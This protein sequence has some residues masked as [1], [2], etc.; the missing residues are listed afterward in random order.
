MKLHFEKYEGTGNDFV[1][2]DAEHVPTGLDWHRLAPRL[3]DRHRGVGA[4]GVLLL[5]PGERAPW[6]MR[7][8]NADG[9]EPEM[10][11]NGV[12]CAVRWW[13]DTGRRGPGL[14]PIETG[15][16]IVHAEALA[17]G[18]VRV[19]MGRPRWHRAALPATGAADAELRDE[20]FTCGD[21]TL[22][23][24]AVSMGNPHAVA[25]VPDVAAVPLAAWGPRMETDPTFPARTNVEFAQ[26]LGPREASMRVWERGA[27]PT[28]ACGTGAC[29][30]L[31][32]LA[33]AGLL[34]REATIHL[35]GGPL[36][37]AWADDDEV[38]MTGEARQVFAGELA[39]DRLVGAARVS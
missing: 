6:R 12:R 9:S 18:D 24:T 21:V 19:A 15:A 7:V 31:V 2:V 16:G 28:Q 20:P 36:T 8:F 37:V 5:G 1:V 39:L 4:D 22:H 23:F 34:A 38:W 29:A 17:A 14:G 27:G 33:R 35:P 3:C 10:C 30:T 25:V 32:V 13:T 11:G 26:V